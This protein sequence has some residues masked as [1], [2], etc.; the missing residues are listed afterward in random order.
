VSGRVDD[1]MET[2]NR[3]SDA[4]RE[5]LHWVVTRDGVRLAVTEI[6]G[7]QGSRAPSVLL[8]HGLAQNRRAFLEGTFPD[9]LLRRGHRVYVGELRGHGQSA[10]GREGPPHSSAIALE[11]YLS[12]DLPALVQWVL[13]KNGGHPI[14]LAGHSLGGVLAYLFS[15][16]ALGAQCLRG[17]VT[18]GAPASVG[19]GRWR[20]RAGGFGAGVLAR[21]SPWERV[22][23]DWGLRWLAPSLA[24]EATV[25][26][27]RLLQELLKLSNPRQANPEAIE[28]VL[29]QCDAVPRSVFAS[30]ATA[31]MRG[32][33]R[34]L[35]FDLVQAVANCPVPLAAVFGTRDLFTP[36][37]SASRI[38]D[39]SP[40]AGP[41]KTIWVPD[42]S[43]V[44]LLI[45]LHLS[46]TLP[47]I[48]NFL[49]RF[50][51]VDK[52]GGNA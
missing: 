1:R 50:G 51:A 4:Y 16:S 35:G 47:E 41:R 30:L 22:P 31:A 3:P 24:R 39:V 18:F 15:A 9:W 42:V 46:K 25:H 45:G 12:E 13:G 38:H 8:L 14:L 26:P 10:G 5:R 44:D 11:D 52:A 43:H 49:E 37:E 33:Q 20:L 32:D 7:T 21:L 23:L 2:R 40:Q 6:L 28:A 36:A 34:V 48:W 17:V 27:R 19:R 29:S